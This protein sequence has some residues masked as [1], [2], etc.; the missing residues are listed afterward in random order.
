V[1]TIVALS[2]PWGRSG[3]GVIRLSGVQARQIVSTVCTGTSSW[4]DRRASLRHI[5]DGDGR[6]IDDVLVVWMKGPRSY[7]GEDVVELSGH[8]NPVVL[9]AIIDAL[10]IAGARPARPG[11]F[12]RRA[13]ENGRM[14]LLRAEALS[15]LIASR[16]MAGVHDA[17]QGLSGALSDGAE[18][19]RERLLD[20]AA[21]LEA[22]LDHPDDD[23]SMDSDEVVAERLDSLATECA[24]LADSWHGSRIRL[25]GASVALV[26][27]VN[28]GKSSLFNH[29]V[30]SERALVSDRPGTTRDV[31]ERGVLLD[32]MDVNFLDTAGERGSSDPLEAA[33]VVMG[34]ALSAEADLVIIVAPGHRPCDAILSDLLERTVDLPRCVVSTFSDQPAHPQALAAEYRVSNIDGT[35]LDALKAAIRVAIGG[36][37]TQSADAVL[38]SQRQHDLYRSVGQHS[39]AAAKA[40]LGAL[41]P[42]VAVT[43]LVMAIERLGELSGI[44]ARE[45]VLDRLFSRFCI[46]K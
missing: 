19:Q 21:E 1:D 18:Q 2:T 11:E 25:Q 26:G 4:V 35:G 22:R 38:T 10:V 36:T 24:V 42:A 3:V 33:G 12:S 13:L 34:R 14:D 43:E 28:A 20:L 32:G 17:R 5:V 15:A 44:D 29:L 39:A 16:S 8:G 27:P 40:L 41:G 46:G 9:S 23:L 37:S 30:G 6:V 31:V 45:A 7:T